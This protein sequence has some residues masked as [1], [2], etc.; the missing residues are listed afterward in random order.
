MW[1]IGMFG[2]RAPRPASKA[3]RALSLARPSETLPRPPQCASS[4]PQRTAH[5][6]SRNRSL[7][8]D[9]PAGY[10]HHSGTHT[11]IV[12]LP[13]F[14]GQVSAMRRISHSFPERAATPS[15]IRLG[16]GTL[17]SSGVG[18][19]CRMPR[20]SRRSLTSVLDGSTRYVD[21]EARFAV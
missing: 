3:L 19:D 4:S 9:S 18:G 7:P 5:Q 13:R 2:S 8:S 14:R 16:L 6:S 15:R 21:S 17:E 10:Q 11:R 1:S 20:R 12:E